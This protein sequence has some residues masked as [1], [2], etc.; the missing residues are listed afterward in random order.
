M[1]LAVGGRHEEALK[2][3]VL[4]ARELDPLSLFINVGVAWIHHFAGRPDGR[5]P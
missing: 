4:H 1:I 3:H 2:E 5:H